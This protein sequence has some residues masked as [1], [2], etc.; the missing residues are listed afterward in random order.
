M[1]LGYLGPPALPSGRPGSG[2]RGGGSLAPPED[3]LQRETAWVG[4]L[5]GDSITAQNAA[6]QGPWSSAGWL[7]GAPEAQLTG[8]RWVTPP[9]R[10]RQ[11]PGREIRGLRT[12][13]CAAAVNGCT[14]RIPPR[15]P[16]APRGGVQLGTP[17][18]SGGTRCPKTR[19]IC[20]YTGG[21]H[22]SGGR[23]SPHAGP[24]L[25]G[26]CTATPQP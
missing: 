7:A 21:A 10:P 12:C 25:G 13:A 9:C 17:M 1:E 4:V 15:V 22:C 11:R 16:G 3:P 23:P 8:T 2:A 26:P 5:T 14:G 18:G 19:C 6:P 20:R 24:P